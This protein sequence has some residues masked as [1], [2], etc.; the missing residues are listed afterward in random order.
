MVISH[1]LVIAVTVIQWDSPIDS[2]IDYSRMEFELCSLEVQ[3]LGQ[4][5]CDSRHIFFAF[6]YL[7][8]K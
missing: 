1:E 6:V 4:G 7:L 8:V 5:L 3:I 2:H